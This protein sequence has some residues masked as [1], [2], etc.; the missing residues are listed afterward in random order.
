MKHVAI[1]VF[2]GFG[3]VNPTLEMTR[4]LVA[5]GH[6]VTYVLDEPFADSV[7]DAGARAVT[8]PS[9]RG[10]LGSG[11]VT[12]EDIGAM[13]LDHLRE[14]MEV[15][16]PR[17]LE[18]L[19]DDVPDLLLY[20][21]ESF[22]TARTA[23]L[24]WD[25]P[26]AQ[27]Y[28][29]IASNEKYSLALEVFDGATDHVQQ[30]ID[31]VAGHLAEEGLDPDA[32]WTYLR[33]YDDRN[34]V[35]LPRAF[36]PAGESFDER[37]EFVGHSLPAELP[38]TGSWQRPA[39]ARRCALVTL[40]TEVNDHRDFFRAA[41]EAFAEGGWHAV[42]A[43][44]RGGLPADPPRGSHLEMHEWV[45][46]HTVLPHVD[47][48]SCH[49]GISTMLQALYHGKPMVIIAFTPEEKVNG[50]RVEELGIGRTL[51]G[52]TLTPAQLRATM[53][54]IASDPDIR[55][56][57]ALLRTHLLAEGGPSRAAL[58]V[59]RWLRE[60]PSG[61]PSWAPWPV[62]PTTETP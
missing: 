10:R 8:Y 60:P 3:H 45:P 51:P 61:P 35:L 15:I 58:V 46:F 21:L 44:G 31:L 9:R 50:R 42:V 57:V 32:V 16:L 47:A 22:F 41:E 43:V 25:R 20:D 12:G 4:C 48:V 56:Q 6:R 39:T 13:G 17:T 28:P 19:A 54:E 53:E 24:R 1:F 59:D 52:D 34:L 36:Q 37:F 5:M 33:N 7:T 38:G 2:P 14:S 23:A 40:G 11:A 55:R 26:T 62:R 27:L 30:C 49:G 18:A 29:Y